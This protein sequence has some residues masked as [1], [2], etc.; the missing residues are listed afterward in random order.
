MKTHC[1]TK[2]SLPTALLSLAGAVL[3]SACS[4]APIEPKL[5]QNVQVLRVGAELHGTERDFP[6]VIQANNLS[7]LSFRVSGEL[8]ELPVT[9]GMQV[10]K[11][12]LLAKIDPADFR[13]QVTDTEATFKLA[14][15]NFGRAQKLIKTGA[16]S[17]SEHDK[18]QAEFLIAKANYE[19]AK[20]DLGFTELRAPKDGTV[21]SVIVDNYENLQVG[22]E[23]LS[24]HDSGHFE[25]QV[26]V[27]EQL[28]ALARRDTPQDLEHQVTFESLPG[29][30]FVAR[31][32]EMETEKDPNTKS[33]RAKLLMENPTDVPI[34]PGM[35][36]VVTVDMSKIE[37]NTFEGLVLPSSAVVFQP[38]SN[39]DGQNAFVWKLADD[40][41][42]VVMQPVQT[43]QLS[44]VGIELKGGVKPGDV[45]VVYGQQQLFE[46]APVNVVS[47]K[48]ING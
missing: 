19:I 30:T 12:D 24:L 23:V 32:Y 13:R 43:G 47:E 4:E 40:E 15:L 26:N 29:K 2:R 22:Q 45:I 34:L 9:S 41:K 3:L 37:R 36:A 48:E 21:G 18:L 39:V 44:K 27:S 20:T 16:I 35:S 17:A 46:G 38:D 6:A 10:K 11:G 7:T 8:I 33:Y 1:V 5:P 14:E 31:S 28:L 42:T 25:V